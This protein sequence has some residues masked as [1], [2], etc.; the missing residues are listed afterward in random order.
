MIRRRGLEK[1]PYL[2]NLEM[3]NYKPREQ[4]WEAECLKCSQSEEGWFPR[5]SLHTDCEARMGDIDLESQ[6]RR[7]RPEHW[8]MPGSR[9]QRHHS[10]IKGNTR[11]R[12]GTQIA[13]TD[14]QTSLRDEEPSITST[15]T[16]TESP[17][18]IFPRHPAKWV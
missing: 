13:E 2:R 3:V 1:I 12:R 4:A 5:L 6:K 17:L 15:G 18:Q 16:S 9:N 14:L 7:E 10:Q 8:G 11:E